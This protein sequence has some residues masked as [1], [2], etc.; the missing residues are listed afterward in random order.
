MKGNKTP[1]EYL[2]PKYS[3]GN[4]NDS[5]SRDTDEVSEDESKN[6]VFV[7]DQRAT[8]FN[9]GKEKV[10][11][12]NFIVEKPVN[13]LHTFTQNQDRLFT[14]QEKLLVGEKPSLEEQ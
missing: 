14:I 4:P 1:I 5:N 11:V 12:H 6:K 3:G 2:Y 7:S 10:Y 8:N 13:A 9:V